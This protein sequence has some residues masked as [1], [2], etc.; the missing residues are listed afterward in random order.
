MTS[1]SVYRAA[2]ADVAAKKLRL[3]SSLQDA[4]ARIA[5][6]RLK[7]DAKNK[8]AAT[9][10]DG[11]AYGAAKIQQRPIAFGAAATAFGLFLA[12]RPIAALLGRLYVKLKNSQ[13][14]SDD[15]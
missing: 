1:E 7:Q 14:E 10:M 15:A 4:R 13:S 3:H 5:P 12:R 6:A 8:A 11:A 2:C 9:L